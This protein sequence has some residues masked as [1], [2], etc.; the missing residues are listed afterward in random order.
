MCTLTGVREGMRPALGWEPKTLFSAAG[1]RVEPP[2]SLPMAKELILEAGRSAD[3]HRHA[4]QHNRFNIAYLVTGKKVL[5]VSVA[6]CI[7][8]GD[9]N[10]QFDASERHDGRRFHEAMIVIADFALHVAG[11]FSIGLW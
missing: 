10:R 8:T 2:P 5:I 7:T 6:L 1:I 11:E 3:A 4:G 9:A